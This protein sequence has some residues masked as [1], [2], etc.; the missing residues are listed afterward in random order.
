M[1]E[2]LRRAMCSQCMNKCFVNVRIKDGKITGQEYAYKE[3]KNRSSNW[4]F[5]EKPAEESSLHGVW[6][7]NI[8]AILDDGPDFRDP[9]TGAW[10]LRGR[11]C[12]VSKA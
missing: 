1:A 6:E 4:W 10:M 5:P 12:R 8:N 2:E 11:L 9:M 7:S 3:I